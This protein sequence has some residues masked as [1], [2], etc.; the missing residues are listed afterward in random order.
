MKKS[1]LNKKTKY[2]LGG[3]TAAF[4]LSTAYS[5]SPVNFVPQMGSILEPN[6]NTSSAIE[7]LK[8]YNS[9]EINCLTCK[10]TAIPMGFGDG[11]YYFELDL[12]RPNNTKQFYFLTLARPAG[13]W[14]VLDIE[15]LHL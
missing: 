15:P 1:L 10:K 7:Y 5:L 14:E 13:H 12:T 3:I 11:T 2:A 6:P 9:P 8:N 4:V